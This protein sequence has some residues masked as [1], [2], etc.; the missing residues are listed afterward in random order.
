MTRTHLQTGMKTEPDITAIV[1]AG[2]QARRMGGRDKGLILLDGRPLV[3][4]VLAR[5]GPQVDHIVISAN[6]NQPAYQRFGWP[7]ISDRNSGY[8]GP[9]SGIVSVMQTVTSRCFVSVPCDAPLLPADLVKRLG[10]ALPDSGA[11]CAVAH[12]GES[13]QPVFALFKDSAEPALSPFIQAGESKAR[14]WHG[15]NG[16]VVVDFSDTPEAF[17]NI[18]T[19]D[20][21][22]TIEQRLTK[23]R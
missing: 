13:I 11:T 14:L 18:N 21:L 10:D 9:L 20:Q 2:G 1:L 5:I 23:K 19:P 22:R 16:S 4:H 6:R 15:R 17:L 12:S 8:H 3:E 7:V